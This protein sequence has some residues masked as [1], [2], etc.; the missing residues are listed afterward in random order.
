MLQ[1]QAALETKIA[2]QPASLTGKL[3]TG[4]TAAVDKRHTKVHKASIPV[5]CPE[6]SAS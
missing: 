5:Q 2:L 6:F 4:L 1:G 3:H